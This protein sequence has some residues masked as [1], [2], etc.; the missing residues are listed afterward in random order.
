[1]SPF[2][3]EAVLGEKRD[4][5]GEGP[6][7]EETRSG[8]SLKVVEISCKSIKVVDA[9]RF[10][11]I[12]A[13]SILSSTDGKNHNHKS[14]VNQNLLNE[15]KAAVESFSE[16]RTE[17]TPTNGSI[18]PNSQ[19][20]TAVESTEDDVKANIDQE[21]PGADG[22]PLT[23]EN[24]ST[25]SDSKTIKAEPD[26]IL[27]CGKCSFETFLKKMMESH[28][29]NYHMKAPLTCNAC[30]FT[31]KSHWT[32][33]FHKK[34]VHLK[35]SY[36]CEVCDF[37]T[38]Y[39]NSLKTHQ[40]MKHSGRKFNCSQCDYGG[41]TKY[42]LRNH[43]KTVHEKVRFECE[44]CGSSFTNVGNLRVH[45]MARH[46]KVKIYQCEH[47]DYTANYRSALNNHI[48]VKHSGRKF[49]CHQPGCNFQSS[50]AACLKAHVDS[51]HEGKKFYCDSCN[52][53]AT[54]KV[55][56]KRHKKLKHEG[57]T[58]DC[59]DCDYI[60]SRKE[61]LMNHIKVRHSSKK[62]SEELN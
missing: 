25:I 44:D 41:T 49:F 46:T 31:S 47:C 11:T 27:K 29:K 30:S 26:M 61:H 18:D 56:L 12:S 17:E 39:P 43:I 8:K 28:M 42:Q 5:S 9:S 58:F 33:R 20:E 59:P 2:V 45:R 7:G 51:E 37:T 35:E 54:R 22:D 34:S 38:I 55:Y 19:G 32:M 60:A 1:M 14:I 24:V 16:D 53:F 50:Y 15:L 62:K 36:S 3:P 10:I 23:A 57:V 21:M 52:F 4:D 13:D 48:A 6:V 40:L